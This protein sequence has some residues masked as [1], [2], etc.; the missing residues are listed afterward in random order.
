MVLNFIPPPSVSMTAMSHPGDRWN[1]LAHVGVFF[2]FFLL[3]SP[4]SPHCQHISTGTIPPVGPFTQLQTAGESQCRWP[5]YMLMWWSTSHGAIHNLFVYACVGWGVVCSMNAH[6]CCNRKVIRHLKELK[7]ICTAHIHIHRH[8][9]SANCLSLS[10]ITS[11]HTSQVIS[12][13]IPV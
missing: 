6:F 4:F 2:F 1:T 12:V 7:L 13:I 3:A 5:C 10:R 9:L 11:L 8:P